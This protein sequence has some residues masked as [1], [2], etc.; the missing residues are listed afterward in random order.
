MKCQFLILQACLWKDTITFEVTQDLP[1]IPFTDITV[2]LNT[3]FNLIGTDSFG[4]IVSLSVDTNQYIQIEKMSDSVIQVI[5][6]DTMTDN[7][8]LSCSIV[9]DDGNQVNKSLSFGTG[10]KWEK[11]ADNFL[12]TNN[13][14]SGVD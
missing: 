10:L 6:K 8:V 11:I 1:D 4:S 9:D 12:D 14:R 5:I 13:I 2:C 3:P 7:F